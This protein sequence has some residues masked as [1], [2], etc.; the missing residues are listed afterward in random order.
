MTDDRTTVQDVAE[1]S[2]FEIRVDGTRAG[3]AAYAAEDGAI[4]F[5]HTEIDDAYEGKGLGGTLV[6][7]ALD[8]VRARQLAVLPECPFVRRW[9]AR[10]PD[11]V[12]LVPEA[13]RARFGL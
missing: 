10:H 9:I 1:R 13:E 7:G 6:R 12:D 5:T 2:R 11:Y 8:A 4:R 3:L